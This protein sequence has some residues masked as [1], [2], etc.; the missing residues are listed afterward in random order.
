[1]RFQRAAKARPKS[2]VFAAILRGV[3]RG[4]ARGLV[5]NAVKPSV[6]KKARKAVRLAKNKKRKLA[7][8]K[9]VKELPEDI[10]KLIRNS[11]KSNGTKP[12]VEDKTMTTAFLGK[13]AVTDF[14]SY[15]K[16]TGGKK[17]LSKAKIQTKEEIKNL[18]S[19]TKEMM[20]EKALEFALQEIDKALILEDKEELEW[21]DEDEM[22]WCDEDEMEECEEEEEEEK[23]Y[24]P[25]ELM[26]NNSESKSNL[27]KDARKQTS[28]P[29][30]IFAIA[31]TGQLCQR[32]PKVNS[33]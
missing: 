27:A 15:S 31:Q 18:K 13:K 7:Q 21:C 22:E 23:C 14:K 33:T 11:T 28:F 17:L 29:H 16:K 26:P 24:L 5:R 1:M 32:L 4:A 12:L 10:K 19:E 30:P 2:F 3:M 9:P 20:Q 6:L 25:S 8:N